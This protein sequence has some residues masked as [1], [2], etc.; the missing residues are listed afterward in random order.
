MTAPVYSAMVLHSEWVHYFQTT[1]RKL[2]W[3][4]TMYHISVKLM[5]AKQGMAHQ[6]VCPTVYPM[7]TQGMVQWAVHW[8]VRQMCS[9]YSTTYGKDEEQYSASM[10]P[11]VPVYSAMV[12]HSEWVHY[13]Q[14]THRK[15][16]WK[17][18]MYHISVKLMEAKQGMA[19]Q[20]VCPTVYPSQHR[21]WYSERYTE[22]YVKCVPDTQ[23]HM[24]KMESSTV[25]VW[26]PQCQRWQ[27]LLRPPHPPHQQWEQRQQSTC[28]S[29]TCKHIPSVKYFTEWTSSTQ[30]TCPQATTTGSETQRL[31]SLEKSPAPTQW[32]DLCEQIPIDEA[33]HSVT[34][35]RLLWRYRT[36]SRGPVQI[37]PE[38][39]AQ[40]CKTCSKENSN[41]PW[42]CFQR[43][44]QVFGGTRHSRRGKGTHWLGQFICNCGK[45]LRKRSLPNHTIKRKLWICLD[46]RDLNEA[47]V[48]EPHHTHSVDEITAKLQGM[49]VFIIVD[50]KKG[51]WMIVHDPDSRKLTCMDIFRSKLDSIFIGMEG[52]TGIADDMVIAGRDEM[53]HDKFPS[54]HG[55]VYEQQP[56]S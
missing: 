39:W 35:F 41:P 26:F 34:L 3:K 8:A 28:K 49:T 23:R 12:L 15:L 2:W 56:D 29:G 36:F 1:H 37:S 5:E 16:W 55:K 54:L 14:T 13:F 48:R 50:F 30:C 31:V 9:R 24:E 4:K 46:P 11:T 21:E 7:S 47:L 42:G 10:I 52:V 43:G 53:K 51:Y 18:T 25:P 38:T 27:L 40:A 45:G 32:K 6:L 20:L 22:Q 33:R 19:H 44:N 17:K